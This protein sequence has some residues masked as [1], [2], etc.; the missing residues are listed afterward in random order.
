MRIC[1]EE[2]SQPHV[3]AKECLLND[4]DGEAEEDRLSI[5]QVENSHESNEWLR[6]HESA[7]YV[8]I[9]SEKHSQPHVSC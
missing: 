6:L 3:P 2:R 8:C 1:S 4:S 5:R 7:D 9:S